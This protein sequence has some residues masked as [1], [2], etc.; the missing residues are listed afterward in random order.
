MLEYTVTFQ[1]PNITTQWFHIYNRGKTPAIA[2]ARKANFVD[3]GLL[4]N[5]F[6]D[7]SDDYLTLTHT[8]QFLD[9]AAYQS[10]LAHPSIQELQ[11]LVN[12]YCT[13]KN[14]AISGT[15]RTV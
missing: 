1:R 13:E 8:M 7:I 2:A 3:T 5:E 9:E 10:Y 14:I 12:S 15:T 11:T 6:K 4:I